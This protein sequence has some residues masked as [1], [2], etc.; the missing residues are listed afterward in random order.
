MRNLDQSPYHMNEAGSQATNTIAMR[1]EPIVPLI[2][3]HAA[4]RERTSLNS[5]TDS[6]EER[7]KSGKLPGYELMFKAEG[8]IIAKRLQEHVD[9][10]GAKFKVSVVTEPS[11]SFRGEDILNFLD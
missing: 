9:I 7:I 4:T 1:G 3:D 5:V 6:N 2:E 11:G 8:N 10:L